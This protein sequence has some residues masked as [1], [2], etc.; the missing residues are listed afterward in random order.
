M[1]LIKCQR[2]RLEQIDRDADFVRALSF[3]FS[4]AFNSVFDRVLWERIL[5]YD[6]KPYINNW[7]VVIDGVVTSFLNININKGVLQRT[8]LGP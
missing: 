3:Y 7:I 8:V 1:V 4:T 6:I 5:S 2:F